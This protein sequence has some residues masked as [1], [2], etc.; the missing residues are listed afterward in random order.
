MF[1][2]FVSP[3]YGG[4]YTEYNLTHFISRKY[5][6]AHIRVQS[7]ANLLNSEQK[8]AEMVEFLYLNHDICANLGEYGLEVAKWVHRLLSSFLDVIFVKIR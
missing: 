5:A 6:Y 2:F 1:V 8:R 7:S 4:I 3:R